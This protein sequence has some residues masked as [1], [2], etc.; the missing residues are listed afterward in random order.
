MCKKAHPLSLLQLRRPVYQII[1]QYRHGRHGF[2]NGYGTGQ[3][4][5][6]VTALRLHGGVN[7]VDVHRML[8]HQEGRYRLEGHAEMD[9][10]TVADAAL[11]ASRMVGV[12]GD[13]SVVVV[14]YVVLLASA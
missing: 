9:V 5:R 6:V 14:E 12:C 3:Y 7:A 11:D 10:L 4:A 13:A 8:F 1:I 2:Y